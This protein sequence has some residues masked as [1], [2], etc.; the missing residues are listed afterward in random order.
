MKNITSRIKSLLLV[1]T[2]LAT[3][4][5]TITGCA[6]KESATQLSTTN[7]PQVKVENSEETTKTTPDA[8][9]LVEL[10]IGYPIGGIDFIDG[11]AGIA[12]ELGYL[13]E[14]LAQAGYSIN[15]I[16]FSG[17]GPAVNEA[18]ASGKIDFA[19]YADFPGIV[20][21]SKGVKTTLLSIITDEMHAG[22]LVAK[23][24]PITSVADLKGKKIAFPKGTYIQ[25]YL[26]QA[27]RAYDIDESDVELINMTTDAE[28]ALLSGAVDAVAS[29]Y[30]LISLIQDKGNGTIINTSRENIDWAGA[31]ILISNT[32]YIEEHRDAGI[33]FIRG[34]IKARDYANSNQ[35]DAYKIFSEKTTLS[36][37]AAK[38]VYESVD[39]TF[40]Y[41]GLELSQRA[42]DKVAADKQFLLDQGLIQDDF[43]V[44][45]W[46]DSGLYEEA[47]AS[48]AK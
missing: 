1:L 8:T 20:L 40:N 9:Q 2:I 33:A 22:L 4:T 47:K 27:L 11:I 26:L 10:N 18:L 38:K 29:T 6:Q 19:L 12:K 30:G 25:K 23:D 3:I 32:K 16:G 24:S 43:D 21:T 31:I 39:G 45:T 46:G 35:E 15:F 37:D 17:A 41:Y 36:L 28:S 5:A 34:L 14:E 42:V 44:A 13:D 7:S 48:I